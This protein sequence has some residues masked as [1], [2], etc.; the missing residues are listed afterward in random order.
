MSEKRKPIHRRFSFWLPRDRAY[1]LA[2]FPRGFTA[3]T[4]RYRQTALRKN[5]AE[6]DMPEPDAELP[7]SEL[8]EN[9]RSEAIA[10]ERWRRERG[11]RS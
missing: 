11:E 8:S 4:E 3:R 1:Y 6:L 9:E 7:D 5:M 2:R 10:R